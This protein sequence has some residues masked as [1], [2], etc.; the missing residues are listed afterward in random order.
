MR[1]DILIRPEREEDYEYINEM[2]LSSFSKGTDYSDG[3]DVV[4]LVKELRT[5]KY[6][7]PCLS[8]VAELDGKIVGHFILT[9]FPLC[10]TF[11]IGNYDKNIIKTDILILAPVSVHF[12]YLRQNI[13]RTM[14]LLGMDEARK[15]GYKGIIV[16]GNPNVYN[17]VG[18]QTSSEFEIY[19]SASCGY[20]QIDPKCLMA[21]E[22][23]DGALKEITGYVD[24]S[25]YN[26]LT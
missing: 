10:K 26:S 1:R 22:L 13:G 14:L 15:M 4:E 24:Y 11:E 5:Q 9:H 18:F 3:T 16:E 2:I 21:Q 8:F 7:I 17:K 20:P 6:Y 19:P 12:E 23:Y 25:M